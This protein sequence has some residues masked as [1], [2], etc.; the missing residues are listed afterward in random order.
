MLL[1]SRTVLLFFIVLVQSSILRADLVDD[2]D[3]DH[4][5][6]APKIKK[7]DP[8]AIEPKA[9]EPVPMSR[10][11]DFPSQKPKIAQPKKPDNCQVFFKGQRLEAQRKKG[12]IELSDNVLVKKC[13]L[14]IRSDQA[15]IYMIPGTD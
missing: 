14:E 6:K 13:D 1:K 12:I 4:L 3:D 5:I 15:T 10:P 11:S 9:N 7:P 8:K 2:I